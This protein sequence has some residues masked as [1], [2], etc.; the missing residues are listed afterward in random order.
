MNRD[1]YISLPCSV[2]ICYTLIMKESFNTQPALFVSATALDPPSLHGLDDTEAVLDWSHL[3]ALMNEIHASRTGRPSYPLLTLLRGLLLGI[4]YK[5]SD[6]QLAASLVRDLLFR[7]FCRL[8]LSANIPDATPVEAAQS[9]PG[10]GSRE[11][12]TLLLG[13]ESE[14]Y[15]DAAYSSAEA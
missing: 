13:D 7:R 5:L 15:A 4:W 1:L 3:E 12:D 14:L 8:E 11:R 10:T 9:G 6:E 2:S